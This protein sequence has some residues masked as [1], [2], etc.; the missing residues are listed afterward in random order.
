MADLCA[1]TKDDLDDKSSDSEFPKATKKTW[2]GMKVKG[3]PKAPK[4][5]KG[6]TSITG[7][8]SRKSTSKPSLK[9]G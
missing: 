8:G 7:L 2:P 5:G 3:A 1:S 6:G 4:I 9:K